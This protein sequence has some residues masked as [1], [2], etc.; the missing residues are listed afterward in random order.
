MCLF[1]RLSTFPDV[2]S[3]TEVPL[4]PMQWPVLMLCSAKAY[5][6]CSLHLASLPPV[7]PMYIS[8]HARRIL[9]TPRTSSSNASLADPGT[10]GYPFWC[11]NRSGIF[12]RSLPISLIMVWRNGIILHNNAFLHFLYFSK[13]VSHTSSFLLIG[14]SPLRRRVTVRKYTHIRPLPDWGP[15]S[16]HLRGYVA[17]PVV[18]RTV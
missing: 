7:C 3:N 5:F 12:F 4:K 2:L 18:V 11:V 16:P 9:Y 13:L 8:P 14:N 10:C 6:R 17:T 15:R 1:T